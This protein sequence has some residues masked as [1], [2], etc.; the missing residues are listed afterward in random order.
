MKR[1][2]VTWH[3][4]E[5]WVAGCRCKTCEKAKRDHDSIA[6]RIPIGAPMWATEPSPAEVDLIEV[7]AEGASGTM[8]LL[9]RGIAA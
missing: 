8:V 4:I 5:R 9:R 1:R 7:V 6:S 3:G 2:A